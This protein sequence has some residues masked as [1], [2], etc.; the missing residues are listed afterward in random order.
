MKTADQQHKISYSSALIVK[1]RGTGNN[2]LRKHSFFILWEMGPKPIY[3]RGTR[4]QVPPPPHPLNI[5]LDLVS[6]NFFGLELEKYLLSIVQYQYKPLCFGM[7]YQ[8]PIYL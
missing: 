1:I 7:E 3:F 8:E 2:I 6:Q 5:G 4:E